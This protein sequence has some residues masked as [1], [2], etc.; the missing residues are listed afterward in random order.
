[1]LILDSRTALG[2]DA[3]LNSPWLTISVNM[4]GQG[5]HLDNVRTVKKWDASHSNIASTS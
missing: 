1:M 4:S 5:R 3:R 2:D